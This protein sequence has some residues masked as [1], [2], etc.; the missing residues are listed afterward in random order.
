MAGPEP[1]GHGRTTPAGQA[2]GY[3]QILREKQKTK[4]QRSQGISG[5][6]GAPRAH[7]FCFLFCFFLEG[8]LHIPDHSSRPG[9]WIC[10]NPS[11]K[12]KIKQRFQGM[13]GRRGHQGPKYFFAFLE[14]SLHIQLP[15]LLAGSVLQKNIENTAHHADLFCCIYI[16]LYA[17]I[18]SIYMHADVTIYVHLYIYVYTYTQYLWLHPGRLIRNPN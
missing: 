13:S 18:P 15:G 17:C 14:G 10:K 9:S 16:Y 7:I 2:A 1:P 3:A 4:K 11:R 6:G 12:Q 8:F 5:M